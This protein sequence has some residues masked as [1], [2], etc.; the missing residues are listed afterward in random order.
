MPNGV[1]GPLAKLADFLAF[2]HPNY[3]VADV[4]LSPVPG[5]LDCTKP[6]TCTFPPFDGHTYGFPSGRREAHWHTISI[7]GV[8]YPGRDPHGRFISPYRLWRELE[9]ILPASLLPGAHT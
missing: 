7:F 2:H 9:V 5:Y 3:G 8:G 1:S 6:C 4:A